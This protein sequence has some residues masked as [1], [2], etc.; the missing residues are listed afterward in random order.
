MVASMARVH[1]DLLMEFGN[2]ER[3]Q[4]GG[5]QLYCLVPLK[6][7]NRKVFFYTL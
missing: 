2:I 7:K 4:H 1:N 6:Q 3:M 5:Q